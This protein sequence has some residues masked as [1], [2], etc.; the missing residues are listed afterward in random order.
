MKDATENNTR[1]WRKEREEL[2][3]KISKAD[4]KV[5]DISGSYENLRQQN[6]VFENQLSNKKSEADRLSK[7]LQESEHRQ[8]NGFTEINMRVRRLPSISYMEMLQNVVH[9]RFSLFCL[10][11]P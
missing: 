10:C 8:Q 1:K 5:I 9:Q 7:R 11:F 6:L 3:A 2:E 4:L